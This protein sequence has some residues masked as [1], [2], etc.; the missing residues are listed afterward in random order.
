MFLSELTTPIER[1]QGV[2]KVRANDY[3]TKLGVDTFKD[4]LALSPRAYEDRT[5][6]TSVKDL[7]AGENVINTKIK[8]Q[9][10]TYFGGFKKNERTLK[11]IVQDLSGTRIS[12]LCFG[13]SFLEKTLQAGSVWFINAT[14]N[15]W[16]GEWQSSAFSVYRT[17]EEAGLGRV[18]PIYPMGGSLTQKSI[19]KDINTILSN[20]YLTFDD[21]LPARLYEKYGLMHTDSAIRL[22]HMPR[23]MEEVRASKRTLALTELLLM[24]I[25]LMRQSSYEKS[26]K[27]S[28][29]SDIEKKLISTLPFSLTKDQIKSLSEIR[30]DLD[31]QKSMNR[32]LQGDVGSGKTLIAW[33]SSLHEIA[34]GHQVAFMAPTELLARQHAEKAAELLEPLGVKIAFITGDV[35]GKGRKYLLEALKNGEVDIAIG[36]HA[37]FSKDVVFKNLR[38]VII[39]EQHRFGVEQRLALT[40]KGEIPHLLLMTAT[41]IPRTLALTM[42]SDLQVSSIHTMPQGRKPITTYLVK[43]E[44]REKMYQTIAVEFKRGHQAYFVY[45]RIEDEGDSGLRDVK[46]M[47]T[48]LQKE[49]PNI[50]SAL[51]HSKVPEDEKMQILTD[52]RAKKISYL[53]ATSVIEVGI[54]I[55]MATCMVIEHAE[56][57]GLAALH[58]LR[59]RVG[60]SDLQSYCFLVYSSSLSDDSKARLRVMKESTDGFYIAEKDLEIRGPGEIAGAK[61]SGFL[62]LRYASLVND[63]D[64]IEIAKKEA[65][66]IIRTDK[67]LI[68]TENYMLRINI[69]QE[70]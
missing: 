43:E 42:F 30:N 17:Q 25:A 5:K 8:V 11:V 23:S 10:H 38:Y 14:V 29:I 58:Q 19:R 54:D 70:G 51:I 6:L 31:N 37:L 13:R 27:K 35:K 12:L 45:P 9:S 1:L 59:G 69:E 53:V 4:L 36:T 33:I 66:E 65:L 22:M 16:N 47:F 52:F 18:I 7:K 40:S 39:D 48:Y 26:N 62:K 57:F 3:H 32:L 67:G 64:L 28:T 20:K 56:R 34:K 49:Y 60:R 2:G 50:P 55:P 21:E 63:I 41:P 15:Q 61:Q 24:E 46:N 44:N 68:S